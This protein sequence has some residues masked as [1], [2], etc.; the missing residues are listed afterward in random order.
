MIRY[1]TPSDH[2]YGDATNPPMPQ[3]SNTYWSPGGPDTPQPAV[4]RD[5]EDR[6]GPSRLRANQLTSSAY[7]SATL[8]FSLT[9]GDSY[10]ALGQTPNDSPEPFACHPQQYMPSVNTVPPYGLG[11]YPVGYPLCPHDPAERS[12][13]LSFRF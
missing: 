8:P 1:P 3:G 13:G 6:H 5:S 7:A 10:P 2:R 4:T 11:E 12:Q 9:H